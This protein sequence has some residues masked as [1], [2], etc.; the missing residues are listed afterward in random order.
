MCCWHQV[1]WCPDGSGIVYTAWPNAPRSLGLT[2][3]NTRSSKLY[4]L[5]VKQQAIEG[6]SVPSDAQPVLLTPDDHSA[7]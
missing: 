3:Y 2:H 5:V 4:H 1:V 6:L 7:M